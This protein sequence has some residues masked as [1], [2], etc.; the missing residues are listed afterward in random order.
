MG[1]FSCKWKNKKKYGIAQILSRTEQEK[2]RH[3]R[4]SDSEQEAQ[5]S[6]L[7]NSSRIHPTLSV[8]SVAASH[9][10]SLHRATGHSPRQKAEYL[11]PT[12]SCHKTVESLVVFW[13]QRGLHHQSHTLVVPF[14]IQGRCVFSCT[15]AS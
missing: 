10:Y 12:V 6:Y 1:T 13:G 7:L 11:S 8:F 14:L 4:I 3:A 2:G 5:E 15:F 9:N